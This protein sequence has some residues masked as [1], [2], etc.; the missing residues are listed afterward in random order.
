MKFSVSLIT[1]LI[2]S[3]LICDKYR[4]TGKK[5]CSKTFMCS[6]PENNKLKYYCEE[7]K[8]V[9]ASKKRKNTCGCGFP[10]QAKCVCFPIFIVQY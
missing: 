6:W 7:N 8:V 5:Y 1:L 2:Y 10:A 4:S 3:L 9:I